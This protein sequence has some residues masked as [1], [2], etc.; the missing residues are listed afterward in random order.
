MKKLFGIILCLCMLLGLMS[1]T[2]F[3]AATDISVTSAA[4]HD[5]GDVKTIGIRFGWSSASATSRL[6]V[7]TSRLRS[8]GEAGTHGTYGDFT[9]MGYYGKMFNSWNA[10]IAQENSFGILYYTDEQRMQSN[11]AN[12]ITLN[13]DE[14]DISMDLDKIYYVYLWTFYRGQ[15]YP[16]N[17]FMVLKVKDGELH[18]AS[19]KD[20]ND[21]G[22]FTVLKSVNLTTPGSSGSSGNAG[23]TDNTENTG[24]SSNSDSSSTQSS[25][26][27]PQT[28]KS[29]NSQSN[30]ELS[31]NEFEWEVLRL[32][33]IERAKEGLNSLRMID[34]LQSACD[35]RVKELESFY[36]HTRPTRQDYKSAIPYGFEWKNQLKT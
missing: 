20:R 17:L 14:G 10:V 7:M 30:T 1:V 2:A 27:I 21:Y 24:S 31:V 8:A 26:N 6:A 9:D 25:S 11:G 18:Y 5:N 3:A 23:N 4:Y 13:F 35:I 33:N 12:S 22:S 34:P 16:D 28:D 19:A 36:S 32:C 29:N 15:Y